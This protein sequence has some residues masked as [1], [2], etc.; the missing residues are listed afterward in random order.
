ME[1]DYE[2]EAIAYGEL[3]EEEGGFDVLLQLTLP[4]VL[5]LALLVVTEV[6]TLQQHVDQLMGDIENTAT[7]HLLQQRDEALLTLQQ[8]LLWKAIEEVMDE[9]VQESGLHHYALVRPT[10]L[11]VLAGSVAEQFKEISTTFAQRFNGQGSYEQSRS[12]LRHRIL[13]RFHHLVS[14]VLSQSPDIR[15]SGASV[16]LDL[17]SESRSFLETELSGHL[18]DQIDQVVAVQLDLTLDWLQERQADELVKTESSRLWDLIQ[19]TI[20]PNPVIDQ[21][22]NLKVSSLEQRLRELDIPLLDETGR[23]VL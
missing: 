7:G 20:K 9:V 22:V 23:Q 2:S 1:H 6:Q 12:Q 18:E 4:M 3:P 13:E 17:S 8:Q 14:H 15:G 16:L 11:E 19:K 10:A 21:F 5:I